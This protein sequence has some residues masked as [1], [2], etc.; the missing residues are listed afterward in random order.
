ML[1]PQDL[2]GLGPLA[3]GEAAL[4]AWAI[5]HL[6]ASPAPV[7]LKLIGLDGAP[8]NFPALVPAHRRNGPACHW[9]LLDGRCAVH[10]H[11]PFGCAFFDSHM[12]AAE[13]LDRKSRAYA[14]MEKS[15]HAEEKRPECADGLFARVCKALT[16]AGR[17]APA[18][19]EIGEHMRK[20]LEQESR[21]KRR[22]AN[23]SQGAAGRNEPCPCG[24]G[25]KFKHCCMGRRRD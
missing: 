22:T 12:E 16:A 9:L 14:E 21:K 20:T 23:P 7:G 17:I 8:I 2:A 15:W 1:I 3:D 24:S 18:P 11:A 6:L 25:R 4:I 13:A 10:E 19:S 5:E